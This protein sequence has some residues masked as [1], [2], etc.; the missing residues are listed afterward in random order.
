MFFGHCRVKNV[1]ESFC[2]Q[3]NI[4]FFFFGHYRNDKSLRAYHYHCVMRQKCRTD[5]YWISPPYLHQSHIIVTVIHI[6]AMLSLN[7]AKKLISKSVSFSSYL[8]EKLWKVSVSL[9]SVC[10]QVLHNANLTWKSNSFCGHQEVL[11]SGWAEDFLSGVGCCQ[12]FIFVGWLYIVNGWN[13]FRNDP[14]NYERIGWGSII[15]GFISKDFLHHP[16]WMIHLFK[17]IFRACISKIFPIIPRLL[18]S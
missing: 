14:A 4:L 12:M 13:V 17:K 5:E 11:N 7:W 10:L 18:F 9:R 6:F 16:N 15:G 8:C 2:S 1:I 3:Y